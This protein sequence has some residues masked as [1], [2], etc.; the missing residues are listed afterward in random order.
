ML[1]TVR[2]AIAPA[3]LLAC[4]LIG[5]SAQGIWGNMVLQVAGIMIIA[6][7]ALER[8]DNRL[9]PAARQVLLLAI[10]GIGIV[11][12]QMLPLPSQIWSHL[13]PRQVVAQ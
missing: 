2:P 5:G 4:L 8:T 9:A 11:V 12:L 7:A 13:G 6:W 10:L 3:Y 1:S